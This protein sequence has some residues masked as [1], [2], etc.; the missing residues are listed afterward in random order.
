MKHSYVNSNYTLNTYNIDKIKNIQNEEQLTLSLIQKNDL[1]GILGT[2]SVTHCPVEKI[3]EKFDLAHISGE[4][5]SIL[6]FEVEMIGDHGAVGF[7]GLTVEQIEEVDR[8]T[9]IS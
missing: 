7:N 9:G 4:I 8:K 5:F 3:T 1:N 6:D 2:F